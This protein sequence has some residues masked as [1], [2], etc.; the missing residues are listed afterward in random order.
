MTNALR[1]IA[2]A[3]TLWAAGAVGLYLMPGVSQ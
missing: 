2:Y 1:L 3:A